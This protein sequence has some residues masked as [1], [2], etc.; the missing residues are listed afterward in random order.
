MAPALL[1]S[2]VAP[3]HFNHVFSRSNEFGK[4]K[5]SHEEQLDQLQPNRRGTGMGSASPKKDPK[6]GYVSSHM[7][8]GFGTALLDSFS[9]W[10][11]PKTTGFD[12]K[13]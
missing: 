9:S 13:T 1:L 7:A 12:M 5:G 8:E 4:D 3:I 10:R 2:D 11:D 6:M